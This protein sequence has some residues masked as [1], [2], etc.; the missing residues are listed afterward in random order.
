MNKKIGL[1]CALMSGLAWPA[2]ASPPP[3]VPL[4]QIGFYIKAEGG[5]AIPLKLKDPEYY[6]NKK[7]GNSGIYGAGAGFQLNKYIRVEASYNKI[8]QFRFHQT[9]SEGVNASRVKQK[10]TSDLAMINAYI[11]IA[12]FNGFIPNVTAGVGTSHNKAG[13]YMY[14]D[15]DAF[16]ESKAKNSFAWNIGAGVSKRICELM[17]V[18]VGYK[19]FDLGKLTSTK[20]LYISDQFIDSDQERIKAKLKA[21]AVMLGFRIHF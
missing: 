15:L 20:D 3:P 14:L 11:D 13:K 12:E 8:D 17:S 5:G 21:H 7:P 2:L 18:D 19:Y 10:I 16:L 1:F 4:G 9:F 6:K